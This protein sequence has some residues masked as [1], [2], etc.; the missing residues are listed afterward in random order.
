[1]TTPPDF[2]NEKVAQVFFRFTKLENF[3]ARL[4]TV[5]YL[6]AKGHDQ[7]NAEITR[8]SAKHRDTHNPKD[9]LT[10][11]IEIKNKSNFHIRP[12][13]N[14]EVKNLATNKIVYTYPVEKI[15]SI[16]PNQSF[17]F[18]Y[19]FHPDS[20]PPGDHEVRLSLNYG[21]LYGKNVLM[22]KTATVVQE[23]KKTA[24]P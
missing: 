2:S 16:Y 14:I 5:F 24:T 21:N 20:I 10:L 11:S 4:G 9:E 12:S 13:G 3:E 15:P 1:M 23:E 8:L 17:A 19:L 6:S 22:E 18:D 7:L